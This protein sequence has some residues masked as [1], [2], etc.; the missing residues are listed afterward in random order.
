M[1]FCVFF[2][3]GDE[4]ADGAGAGEMVFYRDRRGKTIV[5]YVEEHGQTQEETSS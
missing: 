5:D 4:E 2:S 3:M 1:F